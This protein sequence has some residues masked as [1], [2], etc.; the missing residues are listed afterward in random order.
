MFIP[1]YSNV[2]KRL[3]LYFQVYLQPRGYLNKSRKS[4]SYV[5][6]FLCLSGVATLQKTPSLCTVLNG[7]NQVSVLIAGTNQDRIDAVG[8]L[9]V[10]LLTRRVWHPP[11]AMGLSVGLRTLG[12]TTGPTER[13]EEESRQMTFF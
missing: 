11:E 10:C 4:L 2:N 12:P 7:S 5:S 1:R 6:Y 9:K 3:G 13:G 8:F